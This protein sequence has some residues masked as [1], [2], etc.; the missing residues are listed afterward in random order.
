MFEGFI[1]FF[2]SNFY[3]QIKKFLFSRYW[4]G[5]LT[6]FD[7]SFL[8]PKDIVYVTLPIYHAN[9]A[10]I[11]IGSSIVSGATVGKLNLNSN[12]SIINLIN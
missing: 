10:V 7:V 6:F 5:G 3:C 11:G 8:T 4:A 9:G 12:L 1:Y 2:N